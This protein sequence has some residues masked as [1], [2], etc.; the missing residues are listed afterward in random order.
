MCSSMAFTAE[1]S[2]RA[3]L[4]DEAQMLLHRWDHASFTYLL[5][6]EPDQPHMQAHTTQES[7]VSDVFGSPESLQEPTIA[8]VGQESR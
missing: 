4:L 1:A 8:Q 2:S 5:D 7:T 3:Q 6:I